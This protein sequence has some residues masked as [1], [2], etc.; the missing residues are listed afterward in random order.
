MKEILCTVEQPAVGLYPVSTIEIGIEYQREFSGYIYLNTQA[1]YDLT[2]E[3]LTLTIQIRDKA[4]HSSQPAIFPLSF[5]STSQQEPPP[6]NVFQ[7]AD[8]GPIMIH[9]RSIQDGNTLGLQPGPFFY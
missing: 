7:E 8:L 4:G 1:L 6:P 9:L 2:S 3:N 5:S